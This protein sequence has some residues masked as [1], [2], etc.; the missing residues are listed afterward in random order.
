LT[1]WLTCNLFFLDSDHS[2]VTKFRYNHM[3]NKA[4]LAD[5]STHRYKITVLTSY[6]RNYYWLLTIS[7]HL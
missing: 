7:I 5:H 6:C 1:A 2:F 3:A 4:A